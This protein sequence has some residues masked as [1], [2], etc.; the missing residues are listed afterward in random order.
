[1]FDINLFVRGDF[2]L[3]IEN[4]IIKPFLK[5]VRIPK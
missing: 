3:K 2:K 1:M 4:N 5:N